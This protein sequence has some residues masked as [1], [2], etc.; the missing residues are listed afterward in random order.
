MIFRN[1]KFKTSLKKTLKEWIID[2]DFVHL[3]IFKNVPS[4]WF[5]KTWY[6]TPMRANYQAKFMLNKDTTPGSFT[7]FILITSVGLCAFICFKLRYEGVR[8]SYRNWQHSKQHYIFDYA[9]TRNM[10]VRGF[11][12]FHIIKVQPPWAQQKGR[13]YWVIL[14]YFVS[15]KS[16]KINIF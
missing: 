3:S 6:A 5:I 16:L 12:P 15:S 1:L 14:V 9:A 13:M 11:W 4:N 2:I 8:K 7:S 10:Q